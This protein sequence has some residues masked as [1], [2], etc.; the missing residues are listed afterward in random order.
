MASQRPIHE[1]SNDT[2]VPLDGADLRSPS[3]SPEC[4]EQ[5]SQ[6]ILSQLQELV[7]QSVANGEA[8][9]KSLNEFGVSTADWNRQIFEQHVSDQKLQHEL[10]TTTQ[11]LVESRVTSQQV[12]ADRD[13][14][15]QALATEREKTNEMA[16]Q[17]RICREANSTFVRNIAELSQALYNLST[18]TEASIG[19]E[20][21]PRCNA[22]LS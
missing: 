12:M 8:C 4:Q 9:V 1:E 20:R 5:T 10:I 16:K 21:D 19:V 17:L 15:R 6:E 13:T 18:L 3:Y 7:S 22:Q 11:R 2:T 14:L